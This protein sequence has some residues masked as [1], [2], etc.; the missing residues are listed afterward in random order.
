MKKAELSV[1]LIVIAAIALLILVILSV[2]I[3]GTGGRITTGTGCEGVGGQC[4]LGDR[5]RD[6]QDQL[7]PGYTS[8]LTASCPNR[9]IDMVCCIP[10][11][12]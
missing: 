9:D 4:V 5:A 6:C 10:V 3:F 2:L 8:H 11:G 7:G 1:N 12:N